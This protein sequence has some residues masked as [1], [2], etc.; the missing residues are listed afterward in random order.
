M[1]RDALLANPY[2]VVLPLQQIT[3][4]LV[5]VAECEG[6]I[7]GF[8][9]ILPREDGD[10]ELD[11]LFVEPDSW[12]RGIGRT[13]IDHSSISA[14]KNGA[15]YLHVVGNPHAEHFYIACGFETFGTERTQF[16][17]GLLMKRTLS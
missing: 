4:G 16:G 3:D 11:G 2:A 7:K 15:M 10:S 8:A 1:D 6:Q 13:L 5:L 14:R 9:A 12:R 17:F